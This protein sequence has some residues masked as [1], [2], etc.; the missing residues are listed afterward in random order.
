M[1]KKNSPKLPIL[2]ILHHT[3]T[4]FVKK[5]KKENQKKKKKKKCSPSEMINFGGSS[6]SYD[7]CFSFERQTHKEINYSVMHF[8]LK[9]N[10]IFQF[11]VSHLI[12]LSFVHNC[13]YESFYKYDWLFFVLLFKK[14][15]FGINHILVVIHRNFFLNS[16]AF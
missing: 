15:L 16:F 5:K 6:E 1:S 10:L 14:S 13:F 8:L 9:Y 2:M 3:W 7:I 11:S 4:K 12:F